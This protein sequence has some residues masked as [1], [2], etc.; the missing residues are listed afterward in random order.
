MTTTVALADLRIRSN[1][2][3][4]FDEK[5]LNELAASVREN[6]V[7]QPILARPVIDDDGKEVFEVIA[8]ERRFRAATMVGLAEVPVIVREAT[9]A[10][11]EQWSLIENTERSAMSATDEATAA[12]RVLQR[13]QNDKAEAARVLGWSE[14]K[15]TRRLALLQCVPSVRQALTEEKIQLGHAE[16]LATLA[17]DKQETVLA[18]V[19]TQKPSVSRLLEELGKYAQKLADAIFDTQQCASCVHNSAMQGALFD[20]HLGSGHCTNPT[21]FEV[22]TA[23][24]LE[25]KAAPL[26]DEYR[27]VKIYRT[28]D[29]FT[30]LPLVADGPLGVGADQAE[31]C[32]QCE[33]YGVGVSGLPGSA[34]N[35]TE[36]LC[37]E[38]ECNASHVAKRIKAE[39]DA[40]KT[41]LKA[42]ESELQKSGAPSVAG[43]KDA[44]AKTNT[45]AQTPRVIKEYVVKAWR[46]MVAN[47]LE[48]RPDMNTKLLVVL[49]GMDHGRDI[50]GAAFND[51]AEKAMGDSWKDLS[52]R[53][54]RDA[55][56]QV[57]GLNAQVIERLARSSVAAAAF[58]VSES[59]LRTLLNWLDVDEAKHW[60]IDK[61]F[62]SLHTKVEIEQIAKE[63]GLKKAVGEAFQ[64]LRDGKKEP[65]IDGL[66]AARGFDFEGVVPKVMRYERAKRRAKA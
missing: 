11:V 65:F 31:A 47:E 51:A 28:G 42:A 39:K 62:L 57:D 29:G 16:L 48:T 58:G 66:L 59:D 41:A 35:V 25:A 21:H 63:I 30:P 55:T 36:P 1:P 4:Y 50:D 12:Q 33:H 56:S 52:S 20:T 53:V 6:G 23:E 8:G 61:E 17:P 60:R 46:R 54:M 64:K 3:T 32:K 2:R 26:R 10:E 19:L 34:G 24:A 22:L 38:P 37:F 43:A 15:L 9:D 13:R 40:A 45:T 5:A 14:D 7:L 27:V 49:A 44:A 18:G